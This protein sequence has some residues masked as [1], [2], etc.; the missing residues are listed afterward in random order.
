MITWIP[1]VSW[2][3]DLLSSLLIDWCSAKCVYDP[4]TRSQLQKM[5][6]LWCVLGVFLFS[7]PAF[8]FLF[9]HYRP[10]SF[11]NP[12]SGDPGPDTSLQAHAPKDTRSHA[13]V[14]ALPQSTWRR[15]THGNDPS[16]WARPLSGRLLFS[17][18]INTRRGRKERERKLYDWSLTLFVS[19]YSNRNLL[20]RN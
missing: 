18:G 19:G 9:L 6:S 1:S 7:Y 12:V 11:R 8:K 5:S 3:F 13:A 14:P 10:S 17:G 20:T 16:Q 2:P 4:T 15:A